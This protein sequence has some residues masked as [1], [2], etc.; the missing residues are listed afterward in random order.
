MTEP[1]DAI[2]QKVD[3]LQKEGDALA[4]EGDCR[5]A[6]A[7]FQSAWALLPE[8]RLECAAA[9]TVLGAIGDMQFQLGEYREARD[10]F[11]TVMKAFDGAT[12]NP[13][14]CLRLGQAM[15]ELG[16]EKEAASWLAAAYLAEGL[17][18]FEDADPKYLAFIKPQLHPRRVAG[19]KAG[20]LQAMS[21]VIAIMSMSLDGY[22]ADRND[23][24]AE[25]LDTIDASQ[26]GAEHI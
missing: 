24:V 6:L 15:L 3:R 25:V 13:F 20:R 17:A 11:M 1:S 5:G 8:P 9:W 23:G 7:R 10:T 21:K 19:R 12:G 22:V 14:V 26:P 4:D 18:I 2:A 16:E